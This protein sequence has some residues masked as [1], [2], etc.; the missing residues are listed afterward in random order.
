VAE[1]AAELFGR[2]LAPRIVFSGKIGALTEG[3]YASSEAEHFAH[4]AEERGVPRRAM[5]LETESTNT[6][7]NVRLTRALLAAHGPLP[8]SAIAVQKPYMERRT[9]ATFARYWPE[10]KLAVTSPQIPLEAYA[11]EGVPLSRLIEIMVGDLQRIIEYPKRG[12]QAPQ[13]VPPE[14]EA[15]FH[16]LVRLGYTGHLI[17]GLPA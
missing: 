6:G 16:E 15:A 14:I 9:A 13:E 17:D 7:E 10:L 1:R 2:G 4:I 11:P 3:L 8:H 12:F 5:L